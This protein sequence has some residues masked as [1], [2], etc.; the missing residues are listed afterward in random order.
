MTPHLDLAEIARGDDPAALMARRLIVL[1]QNDHLSRDLLE[2]ARTAL[3]GIASD[4][5]WSVVKEHRNATDPLSDEA[6]RKV[7]IRSGIMALNAMF[8]QSEPGDPS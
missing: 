5:R 6:L 2:Q 7:L 1:R 4:E 8:S 3:S